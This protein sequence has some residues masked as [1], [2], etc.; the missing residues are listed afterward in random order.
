[1]VVLSGGGT[2]GHLYPALAIADELRALR[3][4]VR[5]IFVGAERGLEA[6]VLPERGEEHLLLPVFGV[7]RS[8]IFANWRVLTGLVVGLVRVARLF[9]RERPEVVVVTGGYAGAAAGIAAGVMGVPLVLQEQ[10]S[11]PGAVTKLLTRWASRIHV[12]FPEA[13]PRL[14]L[15]PPRVFVSGNPVRARSDSSRETARRV[16]GLPADATVVLVV[17]GSQGSVA[18]N[19]AML[20]LVEEVRSGAIDLPE[21]LHFLWAT[22]SKHF[23]GIREALERDGPP[24]RLHVVAYLEDMPAALAS[25]DVAVSRAGAMSTAELL[26]EGLPAVLVPLPTAAEGHQAHNARA[27][28][29]AGAALVIPQHELT[30]E[31]LAA[32]LV[33]LVSDPDALEGMRGAARSRARPE[34]KAD[35]AADV[36]SLLPPARSSA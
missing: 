36:M 13:I 12:A 22:G 31:T 2:G 35:I 16:F 10:N 6:R 3:P 28:A 25:A 19:G 11:V 24:D 1:V 17:G 26:N 34:A 14:P 23:D 30:G 27:L 7:D 9:V 15:V 8:R 4:D 32:R 20:D 33:A 5:A 21:H 29:A 18:L